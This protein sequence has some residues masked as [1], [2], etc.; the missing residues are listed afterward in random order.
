MNKNTLQLTENHI[1]S[2]SNGMDKALQE[3]QNLL[4]DNPA[5]RENMLT[6]YQKTLHHED[7]EKFGDCSIYKIQR[8]K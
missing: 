2:Y 7:K 1:G 6:Q 4:N 8:T 5:R 3:F